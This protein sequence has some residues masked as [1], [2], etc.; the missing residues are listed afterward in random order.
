MAD[1]SFV[2]EVFRC[3]CLLAVAPVAVERRL[4]GSCASHAVDVLSLL[5][6][7]GALRNKQLVPLRAEKSTPPGPLAL[8]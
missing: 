1:V 6:A 4:G 8:L 3:A 2:S 5:L 7:A